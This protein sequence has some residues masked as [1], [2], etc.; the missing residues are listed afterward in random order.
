MKLEIY[1]D[2]SSRGNPGPA[3]WGV[4][5]LID[6]KK[7]EEYGDYKDNATNSEMEIYAMLYSLD[8][9]L[10]RCNKEDIVD[11]YS[12]SNYVV[13]AINLWMKNWYKNNW[14]KSDKKEIAHLKYWQ[15]IFEKYNEIQNKGIN[16]KINHIKAHNGH[17]YNERADEI[18]TGFAINKRFDL[19]KGLLK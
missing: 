1:T 2:G 11:I 13:Q 15:D 4:L 12:D 17:K 3:G 8:I 16:I 18:C 19:Y 7:I 5:V 6:N 9:V 10:K 14:K